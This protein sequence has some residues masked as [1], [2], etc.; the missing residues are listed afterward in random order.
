MAEE[1]NEILYNVL[2][3]AIDISN[4][5]LNFSLAFALKKLNK[6]RIV[7]F[8]FIFWL[9]V[10]DLLVGATGLIYH[11]GRLLQI[12]NKIKYLL[13]VPVA[14]FLL[15]SGYLTITIA[16]DRCIHMKLLNRYGSFMTIRKSRVLLVLNAI[17][18]VVSLV[19]NHFLK[20]IF[21]SIFL[22]MFFF[23]CIVYISTYNSIRKN[24]KKIELH[25]G[26]KSTALSPQNE[27]Y[28][29]DLINDHKNIGN[30]TCTNNVNQLNVLP[31]QETCLPKQGEEELYRSARKQDMEIFTIS[32]KKNREK[33]EINC[34]KVGV[35]KR[36]A[37][38]EVH[39]S[40]NHDAQKVTIT[41][42]RIKRPEN[43]FGKAMIFVLA[44]FTFAFLPVNVISLLQMLYPKL[45]D[46]SSIRYFNLLPN[47]YAS[48]N[49]LIFVS[50]SSDL[51]RFF[52]TRA[53]KK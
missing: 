3:I 13:H 24:V 21:L 28:C 27:H 15:C 7:S 53:I 32:Y 26:L 22:I 42:K 14:L 11:T 5:V 46:F 19:F 51:K 36:D 1:K 35:K 17:N 40:R 34:H 49:A 48:F 47:C 44:G 6:L 39:L 25:S 4:F 31:N 10:S 9:S 33:T 52:Q 37:A 45:V 12:D 23:L 20:E 38:E 41:R 30:I 16:I 8:L 29:A 2:G 18:A 43:E 50:F